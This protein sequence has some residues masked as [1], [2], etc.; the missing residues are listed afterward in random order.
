MVPI[1]EVF[2]KRVEQFVGRQ[3]VALITF[4]KNQRKDDVM[5]EHLAKLK[6]EEV[7]FVGK[8]QEKTPAIRTERRRDAK[9][10]QPYP[11][12]VKSLGCGSSRTTGWARDFMRLG[13]RRCGRG[14]VP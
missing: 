3:N 8:A 1:T 4:E 14:E 7:L 11:W 12:L 10:G 13:T 9:T 5:K 2:I 6:A